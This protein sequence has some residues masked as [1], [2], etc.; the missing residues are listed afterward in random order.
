MF[1][2]VSIGSI[3]LL[4][5]IFYYAG[6]AVA[7]EN[8]QNDAYCASIGGQREVRHYYQLESGKRKYILIDCETDTQVIEGGLD[9]RSSLDSLQQAL[10][11][12]VLTGK[13]PVIVI[14]DTDGAEGAYEYRIRMAA[15]KAGVLYLNNTAVG[16]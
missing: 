16:Y 14:Y 10:F 1:R 8:T 9:K 5:V 2:I 11:F 12:N 3:I 4:N 6:S 15:E 13:T 7:S